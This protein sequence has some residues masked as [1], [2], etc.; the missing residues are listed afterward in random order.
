MT[1]SLANLRAIMIR[2]LA[3]VAVVLTY[4]VTSVGTQVATT[5]G[6]SAG[7]LTTTT[8]SA[9]AGWGWGRRRYHRGYWWGPRRRW[10]GYGYR[11]RWW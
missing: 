11:R 9:Q 7:A 10:W 5:L 6:I 2:G 4:A 1:E 3:V 8:T